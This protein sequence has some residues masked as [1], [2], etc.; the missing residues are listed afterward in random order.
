MGHNFLCTLLYLNY[1]II[2]E[3]WDTYFNSNNWQS[4]VPA[5]NMFSKVHS[6]IITP[7]TEITWAVNDF[8]VSGSLVS[9]KSMDNFK[10][11]SWVQH[12]KV[13]LLWETIYWAKTEASTVHSEGVEFRGKIFLS[14]FLRKGTSK[15]FHDGKMPRGGVLT[16]SSDEDDRMGRK[17]KT[18]KYPLGFKQNPKKSLDQNFTPKYPMPNFRA[19]KIYSWDYTPRIC[20]NLLPRIFRLFWITQK[21]LPKL[22][23][24]KKSQNWKFQSWSMHEE[25]E[26]GGGEKRQSFSPLPRPRPPAFPFFSTNAPEI[27]SCADYGLIAYSR[28]HPPLSPPQPKD[29]LSYP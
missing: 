20:W 2:T 24:P 13:N 10:D 4:L 12:C 29:I 5:S 9:T 1:I 25:R 7:I 11:S 14:F 21:Y 28:L 19:I 16:I 15:T 8:F 22:S 6:Y 27:I 3:Y 23:N 18:Q 26:E 17:I